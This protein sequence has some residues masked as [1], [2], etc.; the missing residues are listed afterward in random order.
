VLQL[1]AC[2]LSIV[3]FG[4]TLSL[5]AGPDEMASDTQVVPTHADAAFIITK[6]SGLF[7]R[8]GMQ[9]A[10]IKECVSFLND[11]GVYFG[12]LEVVS[13]TEFTRKDCARVMGQIRLVFSGDAEYM[14]GKV[15]LQKDVDSWE[16]FCIMG[17]IKFVEAYEVIVDTVSKAN[18]MNR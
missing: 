12:L 16:S 15:K 4:V 11:H 2:I 1:R 14:G 13:G 8:Y 7:D 6:Y 17:D 10:S 5:S 3:V 9:D 18:E